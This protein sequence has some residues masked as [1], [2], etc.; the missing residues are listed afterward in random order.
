MRRDIRMLASVPGCT[1]MVI[2]GP[3]WRIN[4]T[5]DIYAIE[6]LVID[7][8]IPSTRVRQLEEYVCIVCIR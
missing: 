6:K 3:S 8:P 7:H 4:K 1:R 2:N 5:D